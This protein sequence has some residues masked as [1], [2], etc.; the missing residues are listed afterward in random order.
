MHYILLV[1]K[2]LD[3]NE[4]LEIQPVESLVK[5]FGKSSLQKIIF[6]NLKLIIKKSLPV[7][8][9]GTH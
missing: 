3:S 8:Q 9:L 4:Q 5:T 7:V 1:L 6:T 2:K